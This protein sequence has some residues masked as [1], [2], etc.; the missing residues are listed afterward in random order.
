MI[1]S[2]ITLHYLIIIMYD[3]YIYVQFIYF[4]YHNR[5]IIIYDQFGP[6]NMFCLL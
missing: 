5:L 6:Q 3:V 4:V 1:S 2:P